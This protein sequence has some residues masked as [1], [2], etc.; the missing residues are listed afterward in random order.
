MSH[1]DFF[2]RNSVFL[3]DRTYMCARCK[4]CMCVYARNT[5]L[6]CYILYSYSEHTRCSWRDNTPIYYTNLLH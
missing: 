3:H 4:A 5:C 1:R 2:H 6:L